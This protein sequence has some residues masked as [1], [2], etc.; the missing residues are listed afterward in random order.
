M[1]GITNNHASDSG[2]N[3]RVKGSK[4]ADQINKWAD[5]ATVSNKDKQVSKGHQ[6]IREMAGKLNIKEPTKNK[7]CDIYHEIETKG[8]KGCSQLAKV[9]TVLFIASRIMNI[10]KSIKEILQVDKLLTQRELNSCYKKIKEL[11]PELKN[12]VNLDIKQLTDQAANRL[13]LPQDVN[14]A[15][16]FA[17]SK[18]EDLN[19]LQGR[20]PVTIVGVAIYIVTQLSKDKK[21]CGEIASSV[22]LSEQTIRQAYRDVYDYRQ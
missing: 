2:L 17:A 21:S 14:N 18:I 1:G 11:I 13:H 5:R 8:I 9:S 6:A 10:P 12:K 20:Q 15:A 16:R 7:A 22:N 4:N 19:L 3:T